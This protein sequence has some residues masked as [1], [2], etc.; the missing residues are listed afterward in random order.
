METAVRNKKS[1]AVKKFNIFRSNR[2]SNHRYR[3]A[4]F[5]LLEVMI[6]LAIIGITLTVVIHTVNYHAKIMYENTITTQMYQVAKEKIYDLEK[7][8]ANAKGSVGPLY[9]FENR[10]TRIENSEILELKTTVTGQ[11]KEVSLTEL[12]VK[13]KD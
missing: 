7:N 2:P 13:E 1:D 3:S 4:G 9:T 6:A 10:A 11:G 8:R 5:T 12:V